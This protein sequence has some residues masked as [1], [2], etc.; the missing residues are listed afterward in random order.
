[1]GGVLFRRGFSGQDGP[2]RAVKVRDGVHPGPI[3]FGSRRAPTQRTLPQM[4]RELDSLI[5]SAPS[6]RG[7]SAA[8][9]IARQLQDTP[10]I[11]RLE[12]L[13]SPYK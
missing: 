11:E 4:R 12:R 9:Q 13:N 8:L 5:Q 6:G 7:I 2:K 1:L 3:Y 10:A